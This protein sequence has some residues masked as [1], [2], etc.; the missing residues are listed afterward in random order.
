M[1]FIINSLAVRYQGVELLSDCQRQTIVKSVVGQWCFTF[2]ASGTLAMVSPSLGA[3]L[4]ISEDNPST[5]R[6]VFLRVLGLHRASV[7][8]LQ[9]NV[10][11]SVLWSVFFPEHPSV[12]IHI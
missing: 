7:P 1:I 4:L 6:T 11:G 9:V 2:P 3:D 8:G 5:P 10:R 12:D